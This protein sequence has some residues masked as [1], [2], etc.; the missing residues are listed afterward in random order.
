VINPHNIPPLEVLDVRCL[1]AENSKDSSNTESS[2][3]THCIK[4]EMSSSYD[5]ELP[6]VRAFLSHVASRQ[7]ANVDTSSRLMVMYRIGPEIFSPVFKPS[8]HVSIS[9]ALPGGNGKDA[10]VFS[11]LEAKDLVIDGQCTSENVLSIAQRAM[12]CQQIF[13]DVMWPLSRKALQNAL[14]IDWQTQVGISKQNMWPK[15]ANRPNEGHN[16][17]PDAEALLDILSK[18]W[19][20]VAGTT[21]AELDHLLVVQTLANTWAQQK[22]IGE[23]LIINAT[24]SAAALLESFGLQDAAKEQKALCPRKMELPTQKVKRRPSR[25]D[26]EVPQT[27]H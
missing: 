20:H 19:A 25:W 10:T 13:T 12:R 14:G 5:L 26:G 23:E 18:H 27:I 7:G 15:V 9:S 8:E 21:G 3:L 6:S 17:E 24:T 16:S 1:V 2:N 4:Q 22:E 11:A